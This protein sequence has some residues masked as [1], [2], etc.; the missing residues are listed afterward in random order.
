MTGCLPWTPGVIYT[1]LLSNLFVR[2]NFTISR[3]NKH[4]CCYR[5]SARLTLN[6]TGADTNVSGNSA[7]ELSSLKIASSLRNEFCTCSYSVA[8]FSSMVTSA[9]WLW[10]FLNAPRDGR[11]GKVRFSVIV[12]FSVYVSAHTT[13][14]TA[15]PTISVTNLPK[16]IVSFFIVSW[17]LSWQLHGLGL[18]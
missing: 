5:Y 11:T 6:S 18:V 9:L 4:G 15:V 8:Q 3:C 12:Y 10:M 17:R 13:S 14:R 16:R 2:Q 7:T 1:K